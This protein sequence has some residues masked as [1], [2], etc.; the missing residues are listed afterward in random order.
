[1]KKR[2][3]L[4]YEPKLDFSVLAI[5]S[6]AKAY[7]LCWNINK[8]LN[9]C[10]EKLKDQM[11]NTKTNFSRYFGVTE[12]GVEYNILSNRSKTGY[13]IPDQKSINYFLITK[14]RNWRAEKR[15]IINKLRQNK[16]VLLVFEFDAQKNKYTD[17]FFL[18]DTEN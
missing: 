5:N 3:I 1:M 14:N 16:E 8:T 6:H 13:L 17:R 18:N 9:V 2:Y 4:E 15:Q 12:E 7:K 10:F 11:V